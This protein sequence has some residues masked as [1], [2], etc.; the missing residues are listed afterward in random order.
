MTGLRNYILV[1]AAYWAFTLTDGALRMLVLLHFHRLGYTPVELAFLFVFYEFFGVVTNLVGGFIAARL[2]L[3]VTLLGGLA[4]QVLA[5]GMLALLDPGWGRAASVAYVMGAQALSGIA[6]DLTKMSAKSAIKVLVPPD[7]QSSLFKWVAVLTGSKNALKGVGFFLGGLL[8]GVLGF[9]NSLLAMAAG[10]LLT[11]VFSTA[12]LPRDL[13]R[14][15]GKAKFSHMLSKSREV[16]VLSAARFFLFGARDIWFVVGV[17]VFLATRLSWG[18]TQIGGFLAAWV[19]GY[20]VIQSLTPWLLRRFTRGHAPQG[21]SATVLALLL[22]VV[23]AGVIVGVEA[24]YRADVLVVLGLGLFGVVF[25]INSSV[26]SYLILAYSDGDKV[27]MNVGFYY[28]ANAGGRLAGTVLSGAMYQQWGLTG[29][30]AGSAAFAAA[31]ALL[32]ARLPRT[33]ATF[34]LPAGADLGGD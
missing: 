6:K 13:G 11:L 2:G 4:L 18:F 27:T 17:P 24:G 34:V 10:I 14:A 20:G 19:I 16:N 1:T 3:R 8:L 33:P 25:A 23:I 7:A 32:A 12:S 9:R 31:A 29:C 26:H 21:R 22:A 30:L 28:M 5:L 15:K